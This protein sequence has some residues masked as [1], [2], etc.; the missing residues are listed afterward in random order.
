[1]R[2]VY[3]I[4]LRQAVKVSLLF[5]V[6][7]YEN[8][9]HAYVDRVSK[10]QQLSV[11]ECFSV[12]SA[13]FNPNALTQRRVHGTPIDDYLPPMCRVTDIEDNY[14]SEEMIGN[15]LIQ[16]VTRTWQGSS[17]FFELQ[18]RHLSKQNATVPPLLSLPT[19][20]EADE[21]VPTA[22]EEAPIENKNI[23]ADKDKQPTL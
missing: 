22:I 16:D 2:P 20:I 8:K 4:N 19:A 15:D 7:L 14:N 17:R 6:D 3:G 9:R 23:P 18:Y 10:F 1:M 13:V 21:D 5:S 12:P 11:D